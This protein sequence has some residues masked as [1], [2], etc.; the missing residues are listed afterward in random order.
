[1][2]EERKFLECAHL[3]FNVAFFSPARQLRQL[4]HLPF[5]GQLRNTSKLSRRLQ[6]EG[7]CP[8]SFER[9]QIL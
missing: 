4:L 2:I 7:V 6:Q 5:A 8:R 9:V 3:R 1:M